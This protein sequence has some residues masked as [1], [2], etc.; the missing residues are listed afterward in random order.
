MQAIVDRIPASA[1][2]VLIGEA[3]HGTRDFYAQ[4]WEISKLLIEQRGFKGVVAEVRR[5]ANVCL[6]G[7]SWGNAVAQIVAAIGVSAIQLR[8]CTCN[9]CY[10]YQQQKNVDNRQNGKPCCGC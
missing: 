7:G 9:L 8:C 10:I 5:R 2:F 3:T 4:R 6:L 1:R